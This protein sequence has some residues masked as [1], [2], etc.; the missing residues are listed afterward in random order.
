MQKLES[1]VGPTLTA[2]KIGHV[3][4]VNDLALLGFMLTISLYQT[5]ICLLATG[6]LFQM[7]S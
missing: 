2:T 7:T 5:I 1:R 6:T 3:D 4:R